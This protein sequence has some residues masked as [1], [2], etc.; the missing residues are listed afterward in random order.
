[1]R[2]VTRS[3]LASG[4]SGSLQFL[5]AQFEA[6]LYVYSRGLG[7]AALVEGNLSTRTHA[8]LP[9]RTSHYDLRWHRDHRRSA[10]ASGRESPMIMI[11]PHIGRPSLSPIAHLWQLQ[12]RRKLDVGRPLI[13]PPGEA[14]ARHGCSPPPA[15]WNTRAA[16]CSMQYRQGV[17]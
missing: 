12:P 7:Y 1:M 2:A 6:T 11:Y 17:P 4:P 8:N 5:V 3:S 13:A 10:S 9:L 15:G 16:P 14:V